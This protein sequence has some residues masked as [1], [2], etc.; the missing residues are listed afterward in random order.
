MQEKASRKIAMLKISS[1]NWNFS[2]DIAIFDIDIPAKTNIDIDIANINILL[3]YI[4]FYP[5]TYPCSNRRE[6]NLVKTISRMSNL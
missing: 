6:S 1:I 5:R 4:D 3:Q 2:I